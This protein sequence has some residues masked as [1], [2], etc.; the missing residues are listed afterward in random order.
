M[1][2]PFVDRINATID[3]IARANMND[4][5]VPLDLSRLVLIRATKKKL[6]KVQTAFLLL[7]AKTV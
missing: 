7:Q 1:H 6:S 3:D 2:T 5:R 4:M